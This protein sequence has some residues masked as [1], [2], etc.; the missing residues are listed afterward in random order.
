MIKDVKKVA[1]KYNDSIVGYLAEIEPSVIG[2]QY[3]DAWVKNGFSISPLSL[4]LNN[5]V[6]VSKKELFAG[7]FGVFWDSLPD[8]WG[9]FYASPSRS[10]SCSKG[11]RGIGL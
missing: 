7:L 6:H 11:A 5:S 3:D 1:V 2:F 9:E 4:P 10:H 8:G